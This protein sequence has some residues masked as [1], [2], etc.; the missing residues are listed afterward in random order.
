MKRLR[1]EEY[2]TL[3]PDKC[4]DPNGSTEVLL[5]EKDDLFLPRR[6]CSTHKYSYGRALIVAGSVGF[7]GAPVLAANSCERSGAGLTTLMV[8]QEIYPIAASRCDGAVVTPLPSEAGCA[9]PESLQIILPS[10]KRA[11]ACAVGPGFGTGEQ[12][13]RIL[14][15]ILKE[16]ECPL[17]LDADALTILGKRP[18]LFSV[19][20]SQL[21]LT[22]HEGEFRRLGGTLE[23]GRLN[24]V[25]TFMKEHPD[26][27][28]LLKG[29]G[30][31]ICRGNTV[32]VNPT[33]NPAMAKGGS[34]DV[35]CGILCALLAQGFEPLSAVRRAAWL[36]GRAG[37]LA[38]EETGEYSLAPSDLIRFLPKAFLE[39]QPPQT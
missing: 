31:L 4:P 6:A 9:A 8:P 23:R 37:D 1:A 33:G 22:P 14:S 38:C 28:L 3:F 29:Y 7:S 35:L 36:H 15:D 20:R 32:S 13:A 34:G 2:L 10:L 16:T 17:V 25:L 11:N 27:I 24:G 5:P 21:I 19:C 39:L 30:T 18:E 26:V 12:S